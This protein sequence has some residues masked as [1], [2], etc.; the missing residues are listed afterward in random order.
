ML[1]L[2]IFITYGLQCYVAVDIAWNEYLSVKLEQ[3][4]RQMFWEYFTRTCLVLITCKYF[5]LTSMLSKLLTNF[6]YPSSVSLAVAVPKLD[7]FISLVG[8]FCLSVV[9]MA[10]PAFIDCLTYWN[11]YSGFGFGLMVF[12]NSVLVLFGVFGLVVGTYTSLKTII[13]EFNL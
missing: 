10:L 6:C 7:L 8:A 11:Y 9:G 1:A 3:S 12:K 5:Y 4:K 13:E 2:S